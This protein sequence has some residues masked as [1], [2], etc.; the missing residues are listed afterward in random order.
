MRIMVSGGT[1]FVGRF[2]AEDLAGAGHE[3]AAG[4]RTPPA[5][6]FFSPCVRFVP[7]RLDP[8][9]DQSPAFEGVDAFVHA[10]FDHVPGRYR[11]GEGEDADG[12]RRRNLDGSA[13]LFHQ[14]HDAGVGRIAFISSRAVYGRHPSGTV[15][16]ETTRAQPDTLYGAIKLETE[17]ILEALSGKGA[18]TLSLRVTGVYGPA[19][20]GREDKWSAMIRDWLGGKTIAPRAGTEV[21]GA[22]LA[23]AVRAFVE[24]G[25]GWPR[26][27]NVSDVLV[28]NREILDLARRSLGVDLPLPEA[29]DRASLNPMATDRLAGLGWR[30][31]GMPLFE[32]TVEA[33][34]LRAGATPAD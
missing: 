27:V 4:G 20:A 15:L 10:G 34:A 5:D 3:V 14:A 25:S 32:Q 11:G 12:F 28:D 7:L 6:G 24:A 30:P 18:E 33:L 16:H 31:G 19:G 17:L 23:R 9:A 1:G 13:A 26:V 29:A 8:D 2:I 21:H 22:D